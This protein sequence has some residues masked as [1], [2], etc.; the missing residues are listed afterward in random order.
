MVYGALQGRLPWKILRLF[1]VKHRN[2]E[3]HEIENWLAFAQTTI[4][5][6]G[7]HMDTVSS[8]INVRLPPP[9]AGFRVVSAGNIVGCAHVI[10]QRAFTDQEKNDRWIVNSH[11]DLMTWNV[12]YG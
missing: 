11:I 3:G 6:N 4:P 12:V 10:P 8:F 7:G 5:E 9:S 1:K 2:D